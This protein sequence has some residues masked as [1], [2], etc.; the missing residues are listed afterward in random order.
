MNIKTPISQMTLEEKAGLCSG[1]DFWHTKAVERL[2]IPATMVSDGPHGLRKQDDTGDHLGMNDSIKA[3]CFPAACATAASFDRALLTRMG[4]A[5]GD[6][7]QHERLSVVLGPAVNIKRSPLCGRNFEYFSE[8]P[9][10]TGEIAA[11]YIQG[12]QSRNVGTSIKH[13]AANN[14]EHRRMSSSSDADERTLREIY[15]PGFEIPV[16]K[17]KPWTVMCSYNRINGTY[18]SENPWLLT[19]VL[20]DEW[21]FDGYVMSDWGAVSDR[22]AGV[23]A[24]LDLEM[25]ASGGVNDRKIVEAVKSGRLDEAVLD[26][27]CERILNIVY[28]AVENAKPDTPWDKE[29]QH[30]LSAEIAAECMVLLKNEGDLLPLSKDDAVAFIGEF[31]EKPRFQGGGSS[32]INCFK[33]T[34]ALQAAEGMKVTYARGY[35]VK[36]DCATDAMIAEA[37]A[38]A[39]AAKVAVVFAGLPDAYESE[40]YDRAHMRLPD[41]QT[42]LIEAVAA[43]NPDTVVVLHNGSPVEMPWINSVKG[44]L[45]AYLGGQA[46]GLATVRVLYGDANPSGH[47]AESFPLKLSDNPSYLFYGGEPR[48]TEYREGVFV[49]YRYYDKKEMDVLFPFGHGLS[50]TTFEYSDLRLSADRIK[51][52]DALTVTCTVKNTGA[53]PGKAVAQLYVG[54]VDGDVIRPLRELKGFEKIALAPGES[55]DVVF[56][57]GKRAFAYW[58]DAIHDWHVETG[59]FTVEIGASSRDLPLRAVVNVTS[60]V[61]LPVHYDADSIFMDVMKTPRGRE[62]MKPLLAAMQA[63]FH[64]GEAESAASA[65]AISDDMTLAMLNYMPLRGI[66]SFGGGNLPDGLL[67][68]V[69]ARLNA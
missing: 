25:P 20:R 23:A 56:T 17:A 4:E 13:F 33:T 40:G 31:A 66:L 1:A 21:G 32:H 52:T 61:D 29:A 67:E 35:D 50:Y 49:G 63:T 46:V 62:V 8:D 34:G 11:A 37:V 64:P 42:R 12:V 14:Q 30:L 47:L 53:R 60:T 6:S 5:I 19:Q 54:D 38:A 7:C 59:D 69:I 16:K 43:A 41:C 65:E 10:L 15:F 27:A 51:D 26:L 48:G 3:V 24:G 22:V 68:S 45:E 18:A 28:R 57:L 55:K 39:R 58:S 36:N 9:Y 44:V 2:G